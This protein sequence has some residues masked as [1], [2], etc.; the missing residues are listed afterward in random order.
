GAPHAKTRRTIGPWRRNRCGT[1]RSSVLPSHATRKHPRLCGYY[2]IAERHAHPTTID[3]SIATYVGRSATRS[4]SR[5]GCEETAIAEAERRA[6]V[7]NCEGRCGKRFR[8][9]EPVGRSRGQT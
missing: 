7:A 8:L 4:V 2:P 3:G 1:V 9:T 6:K 5:K